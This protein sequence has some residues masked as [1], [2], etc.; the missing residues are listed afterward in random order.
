[1]DLTDIKKGETAII[2]EIKP[3]CD[4]VINNVYWI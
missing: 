3:D 4:P 2:K 1:M